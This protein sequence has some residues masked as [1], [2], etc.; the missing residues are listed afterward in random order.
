MVSGGA[1][2]VPA[3]AGSPDRAGSPV[4]GS[5]GG[6]GG[7]PPDETADTASPERS[8]RPAEAAGAG[9]VGVAGE[10]VLTLDRW[11][12]IVF[13][14][15]AVVA[16]AV[17]DPLE[18]VA[19]PV[20]LALFVLGC[21]AF[22][23]AYAAAISR[24]RYDEVSVGGAFFLAGDVAPPSVARLLRILL[25]VQVVVA[26][27]VAAARSFTALAFAVLVP[28]V[29]LGLMALWGA[30]HGRFPPRSGA[31]DPPGGAPDEGPPP[32]Q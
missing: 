8:A 12:T 28:M 1:A 9:E 16:G 20:F 6:P 30:Y 26:V 17:P 21:G 2:D 18:L 19:V 5:P 24:S 32:A 10:R 14:V 11:A 4:G 27:A 25:A 23:W 29:G 3:G 13:V 31:G 15:V 7:S 22:L